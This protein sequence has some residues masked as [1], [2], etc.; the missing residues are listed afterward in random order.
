MPLRLSSLRNYRNQL[1]LNI[2]GIS[3]SVHLTVSLIRFFVPASI[4]ANN[5]RMSNG[6]A[7]FE[8]HILLVNLG[9]KL[10]KLSIYA[11]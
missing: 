1:S 7:A 10:F 9:Q 5:P 6:D 4:G 8:A 2:A 3:S 11:L